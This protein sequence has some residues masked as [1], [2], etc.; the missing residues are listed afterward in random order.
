MPA[1][2]LRV[3]GDGSAYTK[4][5]FLG[6]YGEEEG[7]TRWDAAKVAPP[8]KPS[9]DTRGLS[10]VKGNATPPEVRQ[11]LQKFPGFGDGE[12]TIAIQ[13]ELSLETYGLD[14]ADIAG[15]MGLLSLCP[16]IEVVTLDVQKLH[17]K[18]LRGSIP[19]TGNTI[20]LSNKKIT[21]LSVAVI[22]SLLKSNPATKSL[23]LGHNAFGTEGLTHLC[24]G[25]KENNALS[26]LNLR[27]NFLGVAAAPH[28][29]ELLRAHTALTA[30]DLE[31]NE[32]SGTDA[33][34]QGMPSG[35]RTRA[36]RSVTPRGSVGSEGVGSR[37]WQAVTA[38]R[39]SAPSR[40]RSRRTAR[41][42]ASACART[43]CVLRAWSTSADV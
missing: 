42:R 26:T 5:Q 29:S 35:V 38:R 21:V 31:S 41:Y 1:E 16:L 23:Q 32:L 19:S 8:P 4:S 15:I 10:F 7:K 18:Q 20:D 11:V 40:W 43:T 9:N 36:K 12:G 34:G 39:A 25:L 14:V 37:L 3:A 6:Y 2:E 22:A 30:L 17:V 13:K 28:L 33:Y 27:N 24:D